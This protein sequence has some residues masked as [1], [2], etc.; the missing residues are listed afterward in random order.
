VSLY[1]CSACGQRS[2][3]KLA[4]VYWAWVLVDGT[5]RSY[6]QRLCTTCYCMHVLPVAIAAADNVVACPVCHMG[7]LDDMDPV[8]ATIY[9]PRQDRQ[10]AEM[11]LC[12]KC[13]VEIRRRALVG[14][15]QLVDREVGSGGPSPQPVD[16]ADVWA[17][18]GIRPNGRGPE[19]ADA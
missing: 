13:A 8:Y 5:R 2:P 18:L 19:H 10:D 9:L 12:G 14:A 1:P 17:A 7:T 4:Q 6:K 15:E 3:G 11:A 16:P